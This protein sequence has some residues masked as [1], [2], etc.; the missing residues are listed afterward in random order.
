MLERIE[1]ILKNL[2]HIKYL[3]HMEFNE[4]MNSLKR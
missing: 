1:H 4:K 3:I 2:E